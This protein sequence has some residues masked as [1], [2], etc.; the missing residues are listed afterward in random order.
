MDLGFT[1]AKEE[2]ILKR[3][4]RHWMSLMPVFVS[5][6]TIIVLII[7]LSYMLGR[8]R[9]KYFNRISNDNI[10]GIFFALSV[11]ALAILVGGVWVYRRNCLILTN[12]HLIRV[13][14]RGLFA[15]NVSQLSLTRVQDVS[16]VTPGFFATIFGYG[17]VTVETAGEE[18][19]FVMHMVPYP[20][21]IADDCINAHDQCVEDLQAKHIDLTKEVL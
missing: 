4:N 16:G 12:R 8:Y 21:V 3:V 14:Q 19:N 13:E 7:G 18:E 6:G 1:L 2:K 11:I 15:R 17:N 9:Q 20:A 10:I 5:T